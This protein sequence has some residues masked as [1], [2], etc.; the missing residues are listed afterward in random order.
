MNL[1]DIKNVKLLKENEIDYPD[2]EKEKRVKLCL[3]PTSAIYLYDKDENGNFVE[4]GGYSEKIDFNGNIYRGVLDREDKNGHIIVRGV[5]LEKYGAPDEELILNVRDV[6]SN[7]ETSLFI[8]SKGDSIFIRQ[9]F[10]MVDHFY[11][12][13]RDEKG[14]I[15]TSIDNNGIKL[16]DEGKE[17]TFIYTFIDEG[18]DFD[19]ALI[20]PHGETIMYQSDFPLKTYKYRGTNMLFKYVD[21][22]RPFYYY[23]LNNEKYY[24][25]PKTKEDKL[26]ESGKNV[27]KL[28]QKVKAEAHKQLEQMGLSKYDRKSKTYI[29]TESVTKGR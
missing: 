5:A 28:I 10:D 25:D 9:F 20:A 16:F 8:G 29:P 4:E 11:S 1:Q 18:V 13:Y 21:E 3:T 15:V 22:S 12:F 2:N 23:T 17:K 6:V 26:I 27:E 7:T 19:K 14:N 24:Y